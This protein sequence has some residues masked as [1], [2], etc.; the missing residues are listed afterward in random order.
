MARIA[1]PD[2]VPGRAA[3]SGFIHAVAGG[4]IWYFMSPGRA[5]A[6]KAYLP[7]LAPQMFGSAFIPATALYA[8]AV[9][10]FVSAFDP[11]PAVTAA[12]LAGVV[13]FDDTSPQPIGTVGQT[14]SATAPRWPSSPASASLEWS[15]KT[16]RRPASSPGRSALS[17]RPVRPE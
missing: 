17:T 4:E 10:A 15:A 6:A 9:G 7:A 3:I 5:V 8:V 1:Q 12:R 16:S 2:V 13:H 11:T 14:G